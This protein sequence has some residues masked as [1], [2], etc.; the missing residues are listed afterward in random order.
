MQGDAFR[1]KVADLLRAVY[2][3]V[4][5]EVHF[6]GKNADVAFDMLVPPRTKFV[7]AVECKDWKTPLKSADFQQICTEYSTAFS[8]KK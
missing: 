2:E 1:K 7:V 3:N 4:R 6:S 5:E 8:K